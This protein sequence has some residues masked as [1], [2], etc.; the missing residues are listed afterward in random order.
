MS[1][2]G[3]SG[4]VLPGVWAAPLV[5]H[6]ASLLDFTQSESA[7]DVVAAVKVAREQSLVA[8][9]ISDDGVLLVG[10]TAERGPIY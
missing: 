8:Q 4:D 2:G 5:G 7:V 6:P 10:W 3:R 9:I 1:G